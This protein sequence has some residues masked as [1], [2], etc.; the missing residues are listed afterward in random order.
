MQRNRRN[1]VILRDIGGQALLVEACQHQVGP[2]C[3][4]CQCR[5]LVQLDL[6]NMLDNVG[7][8]A[9]RVFDLRHD[10]ADQIRAR[11]HLLARVRSER[12]TG[13]PRRL[14]EAKHVR[15]H[16]HL[17][18]VSSTQQLPSNGHAR[19]NI[20]ATAIACH[21]KFHRRNLTGGDVDT[22]KYAQNRTATVFSTARRNRSPVSRNARAARCLPGV[23]LR[24]QGFRPAWSYGRPPR[25][26]G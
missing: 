7:H 9:E 21:H 26:L 3:Q 25:G 20:A 22:S 16:C 2:I 10:P 13:K 15:W 8:D 14:D 11:V 19:L 18:V 5:A 24:W 6:G 17:H 12:D 4:R 1:A 23:Q